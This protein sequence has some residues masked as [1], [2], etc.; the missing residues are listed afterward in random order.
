MMKYSWNSGGARK[1]FSTRI[2]IILFILACSGSVLTFFSLNLD[3]GKYRYHAGEIT[4]ETL[5]ASKAIVDAESTENL[6]EQALKS[7]LPVEYVEPV[8]LIEVKKD[9]DRVFTAVRNALEAFPEDPELVTALLMDTSFTGGFQFEK[10]EAEALAETDLKTITA[11]QQDLTDLLSQSLANGVTDSQLELEKTKISQTVDTLREYKGPIRSF[12]GRAA[13]ELLRSNRFVDQKVTDLRKEEARNAVEPVMISKGAV[14][15][16]AGTLLNESHIN[17]LL[18]AD[19]LV[20]ESGER[21]LQL[22]GAALLIFLAVVYLTAYFYTQGGILREPRL[23]YLIGILMVSMLGIAFLTK[24]ISPWLYPFGFF[25]MLV[26]LLVDFRTAAILNTFLCLLIA[27]FFKV[28]PSLVVLFWFAGFSS[29]ISIRRAEQRSSL[30]LAGLAGS[31]VGVLLVFGMGFAS[32]DGFQELLYRGAFTGIAG[33][34]SSILLLGSMPV[35]EIGFKILTPITLL[36]LSNPSHPLL[37]KLLVEAPGTYHHSILVGNLSESAAHAIGANALLTRVG[38]FY[39][40]IGKVNTPQYFV[41]NQLGGYNP[42]DALPPEI[43]AKLIRDHVEIGLRLAAEYRLPREIMD[44]IEQHHG[45]TLIRYFYHKA[46]LDP[47]AGALDTDMYSY[48]GKTPRT[49]EAAIIMLADSVEAAVRSLPDIRTESVKSMIAK[50][51]EE[52][53]TTGQLSQS[54]LTFSDLTIIAERFETI[55]A[56]VYHERIQYPEIKAITQ[57]E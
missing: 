22:L 34:V 39:H 10:T 23:I 6:Q 43:S 4:K 13:S 52:K 54:P 19:M 12:G 2:L 33:I 25:P 57:E 37:K 16:S 3:Q 21:S 46:S 41:E 5:I 48:S 17:L 53:L 55:L 32:G 50:V 40:D 24:G 18:E 44:I 29:A 15:A 1:F 28:D 35:W 27:A 49:R 51:F 47:E 38:S 14:I 26:A 8:I 56:G 45:N 42:H 9:L 11:L 7:I 31:V 30:F 36:E 20:Q